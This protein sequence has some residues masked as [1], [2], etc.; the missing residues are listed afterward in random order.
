[1]MLCEKIEAEL[2]KYPIDYFT[3]HF[4]IDSLA[5][6]IT[7]R[8][9]NRCAHCANNSSP[10]SEEIVDI[11]LLNKVVNV[12]LEAGISKISFWGGE[13]FLYPDFEAVLTN[14]LEK[15]MTIILV[16]NGFWAKSRDTV[17][18]FIDKF[19]PLL[20]ERQNIVFFISCDE[21]HQSQKATPLANVANLIAVGEENTDKFFYQIQSV[22][23]KDDQTVF[24]L[25][26]LLAE[27]YGLQGKITEIKEKQYY[28]PLEYIGR[29]AALPREATP[30][31]YELSAGHELP[32]VAVFVAVSGDCVLY[33]N[34]VGGKILPFGNIQTDN[35][36]VVENNLN[37]KKIL[38]L[39]HF[40]P[41]KYFFYP[42]RKY[43][44]EAEFTG[45]ESDRGRMLRFLR[46][47]EKQLDRS[48]ELEQ[49]RKLYAG[50]LDE[51]A[52]LEALDMIENYGDL[53]DVF[54]LKELLQKNLDRDIKQKIQIVLNEVY[55]PN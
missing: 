15:G 10:D 23:T 31:P 44:N 35:L 7:K 48:A 13:P 11:N 1:M 51:I 42:F 19:R 54:Y 6:E 34:W 52:A 33:D 21:F 4:R 22:W 16:T 9:T 38:K 41:P 2:E 12:C 18:K 55:S 3:H 26:D 28:V 27:Q 49:A 32:N 36:A 17:Q 25:Y 50:Q 45:G 29:G 37:D 40:Y 46:V 53:S 30:C 43:L 47:K 14:C 20:K 24:K 8:C 39:I 5:L